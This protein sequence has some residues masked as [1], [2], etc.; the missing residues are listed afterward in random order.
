M[1]APPW[2]GLH[3]LHMRLQTKF[4]QFVTV[5]NT[6]LGETRLRIKVKS[7]PKTVWDVLSNTTHS[8]KL[9]GSSSRYSSPE[10]T[11]YC[12]VPSSATCNKCNTIRLGKGEVIILKGLAKPELL[13]LPLAWWKRKTNRINWG[14]F[15][16]ELN[17][18]SEKP[19]KLLII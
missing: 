8:K 17:C 15:L 9:R 6:T 3:H 14:V 18:Q 11:F 5:W 4:T 1:D 12:F 2:A 16:L 7:K 19:E 10:L 13:F